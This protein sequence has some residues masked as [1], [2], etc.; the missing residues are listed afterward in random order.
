MIGSDTVG[1]FSHL[2][3]EI[4][5]HYAFLDALKPSTARRVAGDNFLSVL[6]RRVRA[7]L[8]EAA[9]NVPGP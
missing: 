7:E 4:Q 9:K 5:K 6:P 2:P 1:H 3:A 8:R